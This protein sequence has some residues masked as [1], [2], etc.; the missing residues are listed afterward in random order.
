MR[1]MVGKRIQFSGKV[2]EVYDDRS[3]L[4][5]DDFCGKLFTFVH[6]YEIPYLNLLLINKD[7][8]A[9]GYGTIRSIDTFL[10]IRIDINVTSF[11]IQ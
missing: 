10:G 6:L 1:D 3:V 2:V 7:D 11:N 9:T 4:I 8:Y 5:S